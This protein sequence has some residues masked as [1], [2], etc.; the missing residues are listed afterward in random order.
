MRGESVAAKPEAINMVTHRCKKRF[1]FFYSGHVFTFL[2]FFF[3][4]PSV[5]LFKKKRWQVQ[6]S[7]QVIKKH[8]QNNSNEIDL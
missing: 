8:F 5:F 1:T 6:S 4:F 3:Y 7:K 2:A